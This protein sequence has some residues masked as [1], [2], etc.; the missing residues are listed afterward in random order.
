MSDI[1]KRNPLS[2]QKLQE[3]DIAVKTGIVITERY[4]LD[5]ISARVHVEATGDFADSQKVIRYAFSDD[6]LD[7]NTGM[8][9]GDGDVLELETIEQVNSFKFITAE[10]T[11]E[12][13]LQIQ[14]FENLTNG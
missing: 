14:L 4:L 13:T 9:L 1:R 8:L 6:G 7:V 10:D 3:S 2:F 11:I 12:A 5:D